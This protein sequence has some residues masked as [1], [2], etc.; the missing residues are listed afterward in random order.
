MTLYSGFRGQHAAQ[1]GHGR[2]FPA[3]VVAEVEYDLGDLLLLKRRKDLFQPADRFGDEIA[4][5]KVTYFVACPVDYR[6]GD[7]G[8]Q[9]HLHS[10]ESSCLGRRVDRV[11]F[12]VSVLEGYVGEPEKIHVRVHRDLHVVHTDEN[13]PAFDARFGSRGVRIGKQDDREHVLRIV[14]L[15]EREFVAVRAGFI[16]KFALG[17]LDIVA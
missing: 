17:L 10:G 2:N 15:A 1:F 12:E 13:I 3:G 6:V 11:S 5:T 4:I 14:E 16:G 9:I 8:I 7:H